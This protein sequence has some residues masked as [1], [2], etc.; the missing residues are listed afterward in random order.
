MVHQT[1][2]LS[3]LSEVV[4]DEDG[5]KQINMAV[6]VWELGIML[7]F[8]IVIVAVSMILGLNVMDQA[9]LSQ[10]VS[11]ILSL[12]F[13]AVTM[14]HLGER[15]AKVRCSELQSYKLKN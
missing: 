1:S 13:F 12:P 3:Y 11:S 10:G 4:D 6:R 2:I 5:L 9:T 14:R 7:S 8:M 15:K